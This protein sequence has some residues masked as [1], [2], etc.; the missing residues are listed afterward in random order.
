[1][2]KE[3]DKKVLTLKHMKL[4]IGNITMKYITSTLKSLHFTLKSFLHENVGSGLIER[5]AYLIFYVLEEGPR[6]GLIERGLNREGA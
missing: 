3:L 6:R 4:E 2:K 5:G 1:M